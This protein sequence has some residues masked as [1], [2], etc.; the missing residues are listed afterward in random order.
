MPGLCTARGL[1]HGASAADI[2]VSR[3]GLRTVSTNSRP[4]SATDGF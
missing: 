3:S 1:R 2:A 4:A